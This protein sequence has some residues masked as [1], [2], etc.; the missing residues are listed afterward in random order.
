MLQPR[1]APGL[2]F[3]AD[4]WTIHVKDAIQ[5]VSIDN[6]LNLCFQ[7]NT[8]FCPLITRVNGVVTQVTTFPANLAVQITGGIDFEGSYRFAIDDVVSGWAGNMGMH[9]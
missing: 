9:A 8:S 2:S 1:F 3:S 6:V 7:G 5:S 4:Y